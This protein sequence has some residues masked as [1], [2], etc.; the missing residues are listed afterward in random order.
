MSIY[1]KNNESDPFSE[2]LNSN[3]QQPVKNDFES[4]QLNIN[5]EDIENQRTGDTTQKDSPTSCFFSHGHSTNS[6]NIPISYFF[7][8]G[9]STNNANDLNNEE[10]SI[11]F[12]SPTNDLNLN[13]NETEKYCKSQKKEYFKIEK[14]D[15][16]PKGNSKKYNAMLTIKTHFFSFLIALT[17]DYKK[18]KLQV[19]GLQFRN[20][21]RSEIIKTDIQTNKELLNWSLG[22]LLNEYSIT[23]KC[24]LDKKTNQTNLTELIKIAPSISV[25]INMKIKELFNNVKLSQ[26]YEMLKKNYGLETAI[27]FYQFIEKLKEKKSKKKSKKKSIKYINN[28]VSLAKNYVN[29]FQQSKPRRRHNKH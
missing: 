1:L 23:S 7:S 26:D 4:W 16:N 12:F 10:P 20:I 14:V 11:N 3:E 24:T 8:Y 28:L 22:K 19:E 9:H 21:L 25:L 17:N 6:A 29:H 2:H 13:T 5:Q 15:K 27:P 18:N